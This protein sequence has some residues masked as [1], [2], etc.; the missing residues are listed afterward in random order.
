M[1]TRVVSLV[2]FPI[3]CPHLILKDC[4]LPLK[5]LPNNCTYKTLRWGEFIS[6]RALGIK[7]CQHVLFHLSAFQFFV[8]IWYLNIVLFLSKCNAS[9]LIIVHLKLLDGVNLHLKELWGS[10]D[11]NT[12]CFT[13]LFSNSCP[14]LI[15]EDCPLP[16]KVHFRLHINSHNFWKWTNANSMKIFSRATTASKL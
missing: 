14:Q 15:L 4:P 2:C 5:V 3:P 16:H 8:H 6:E 1:P 9:F 13:C 12:C 10:S 7:W 11:A